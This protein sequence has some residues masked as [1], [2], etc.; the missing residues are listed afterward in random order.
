MVGEEPA[1]TA[2]TGLL[3][4]LWGSILWLWSPPAAASTGSSSSEDC[5]CKFGGCSP[6][7]LKEHVSALYNL[8][9]WRCLAVL[10]GSIVGSAAGRSFD[11]LGFLRGLS[12]LLPSQEPPDTSI[13]GECASERTALHSIS[14]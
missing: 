7:E 8:G 13:T 6:D 4:L 3:G 10:G 5:R 11:E 12:F 14:L 2:L 9:W 1:Y